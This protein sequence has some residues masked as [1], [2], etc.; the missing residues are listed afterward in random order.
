[1]H[2]PTLDSALPT[3]PLAMDEAAVSQRFRQQWSAA[4]PAPLVK[5]CRRQE[6]QYRP[7]QHCLVTYKLAIEP[8]GAAPYQTIIAVAATPAG[9]SQRSF[10]AD[11][12]L[13]GLATAGTPEAMQERLI[14]LPQTP[15]LD[16]M[17]SRLTVTPLR[18][19]AGV[20]CALRYDVQQEA[21]STPYFGK[22]VAG[23]SAHLA[24][25][26][27]LLTAASQAEP[28][29]PHIAPLLAYWSDLDM[30]VQAAMPGAELHRVAFDDRLATDTRLAWLETAGRAIAALHSLSVPANCPGVGAPQWLADDV[31]GLSAY[32]PAIAQVNPDLA[33][34][35]VE[36]VA[37]LT[38]R[39]AHCA[40]AA[41]VVTH[42]A[43]RT[44]QFL[45]DGAHLVL[46]DLDSVCW[47]SPARDLGNFLA[48][49]TWKALRQPADAL[50]IQQAQQA[51][52]A[53]YQTHR[54]L[55]EA[56]WLT[57]YQAAALLKIIGRRYTGL[58]VQEWPLT[59]T[60]LTQTLALLMKGK[61]EL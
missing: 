48:Y 28:V 38:D 3:L 29:L 52:L 39:T 35:F 51:F 56:A 24:Q 8:V 61:N 20:R 12:H 21:R 31:A 14:A 2:W 13:G 33:A 50:F 55:P 23:Q 26:I 1:M 32:I 43:L 58:T 25:T 17:E 53:G 44:D 7:A 34:R 54:A 37:L 40:E 4:G 10:T 46:I 16:G 6:I 42:G 9:I 59:A 15:G 18:Y 5:E 19:K 49:L 41:P 22:L 30:V 27:T 60:L 47:A 45:L 36:V 57:F 11:P